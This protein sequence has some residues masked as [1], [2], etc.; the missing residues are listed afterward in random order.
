[1]DREGVTIYRGEYIHESV[2]IGRGTRIGAG[3]D[4]GK[5]VVIGENCDIQC[6]V[7]ISNE[8]KIGNRIFIGPG[9]RFFNDKYPPNKRLQAGVVED[10]AVIG[11]GVL[12]GPGVRIG[13]GAVTGMGA[14]I[15]KDVASL[16]VVVDD[17]SRRLYMRSEYDKKRSKYESDKFT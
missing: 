2:K 12:I 8:W 6:G 15:R 14:M 13:C 9:V 10:D 1:M 17:G 11:G 5:D 3:H 4:I 16:Q 7:F